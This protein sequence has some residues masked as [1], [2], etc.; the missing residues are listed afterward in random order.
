MTD[1]INLE[2]AQ[3]VEQYVFGSIFIVLVS[4]LIYFIRR[5]EKKDEDLKDISTKVIQA[6]GENNEI[7]RNNT[8]M[9]NSIKRRLNNDR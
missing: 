5:I 6:L 3:H 7:I 2:Q 1:M 4:A 9:L 8:E